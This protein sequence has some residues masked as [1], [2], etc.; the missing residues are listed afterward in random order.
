MLTDENYT[1]AY[2]VDP[3]RKF[4]NGFDL[5]PFSNSTANQTIQAENFFTVAENGLEQDWTNYERKWIN[6]PYSK[7]LIELAI[8]KTLTYAGIGESLL[9]VNTSSSTKW[10]HACMSVCVAYLHPYKRIN[11]DSPYRQ[12]KGNR[13]DQ[14]LFYFGSRPYEFA[15]DLLPLG[16]S[17]QPIN[18]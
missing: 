1:P 16:R 8:V 10:F 14:T 5:D 13:Y 11:F 3:C 15:V 12:N 6:P 7:P 2:F 9:L 18:I 4:L 17:V